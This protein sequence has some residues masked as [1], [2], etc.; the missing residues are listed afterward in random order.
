MKQIQL[1]FSN[2][3]LLENSQRMKVDYILTE[4]VSEEDQRTPYYGVKITKYQGDTIESEEV[5]GISTVKDSVISIIQKL[6]Q[7]EVT[8]I[9]MI[10]IVDE[11]VTDWAM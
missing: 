6:Y 3:I 8:P 4:R 7:H 1:L 5:C 2:S 9:S 11:L 10:E